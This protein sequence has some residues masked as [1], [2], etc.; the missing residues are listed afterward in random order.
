MINPADIDL[1]DFLTRWHGTPQSSARPLPAETSWLPGPLQ[2]WHGLASRWTRLH[3]GG[4]RMTDPSRIQ[5]DQGKAVFMKDATGD[6]IWAFAAEDPDAVYEGIPGGQL[7]RVPE[8]LTEFLTHVT[9]TETLMSV[10][11]ARLGDQVPDGELPSIL[12]PMREIGF[13]GWKWPDPGNR[14]FMSDSLLATVGPAID[15]ASPWL[16]RSGYSAV[17]IAGINASE[18]GYLDADTTVKW[19]EREPDDDC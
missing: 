18:L 11:F 3:R 19:I 10:D 6:W 2:E 15:P 8:S 17:R 5:V 7:D 4:N 13:G 16:N 1:V 14:T 12:A 9:V